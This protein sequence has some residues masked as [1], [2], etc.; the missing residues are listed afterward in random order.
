MGS[1]FVFW[2][3]VGY[4]FG[5]KGGLIAAYKNEKNE[6]EVTKNYCQTIHIYLNDETLDLDRPVTIRSQG[7]VAFDGMI[8]RTT[9]TI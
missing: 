5:E 8:P 2:A 4:A 3:V 9:K 7:K 1:T 6:I